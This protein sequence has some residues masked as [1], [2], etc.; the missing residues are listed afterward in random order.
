[1]IG[2]VTAVLHVSTSAS[3]TDFTAK[4]VDVHLDG[5]AILIC[6][7]ILALRHRESLDRTSAV[8]AGE[9]YELTVTLGPTANR[10]RRGHRLRLEI[11]SSNF[12]R[13]ARNPNNGVAPTMAT[14][15]DL[16]T[17]RQTVRHDATH[18]SRLVLPV[19][20]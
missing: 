16:T 18:P 3:D 9:A 14:A 20:G 17:A 12:P 8:E 10:F 15:A 5:R 1:V 6:D 4:L 19:R 7:G 11:S 13:F 2:V